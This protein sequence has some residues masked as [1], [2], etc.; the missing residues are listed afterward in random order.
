MAKDIK[1]LDLMI[2]GGG[3][4]GL[5]AAIYASRAKLN[6][7]LLE[8]ALVGGQIRQTF[9][10]ENYPG[11]KQIDGNELADRMQQQAIEL[12]ASIEEFDN[13]IS[14]KLSDDEKIIETESYIYK[15]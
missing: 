15:L 7:L 14:V 5:S 13:I 3:P 10:V 8:N 11:F 2:I 12:G 4:A 6:L 1:N 9:T